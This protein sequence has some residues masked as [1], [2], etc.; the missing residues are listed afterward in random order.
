MFTEK[1]IE[2]VILA[3]E[4][5]GI[6]TRN[7]CKNIDSRVLSDEIYEELSK[8]GYS[9]IGMIEEHLDGFTDYSRA[10][11]DTNRMD[12]HEANKYLKQYV[13]KD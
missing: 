1:D 8:R 13:L 10:I 9:S 6:V 4:K 12:F 3:Y 7:D 2:T 11:Y 5:N